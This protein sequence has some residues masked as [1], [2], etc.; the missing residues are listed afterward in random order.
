MKAMVLP[1]PGRPLELREVP[2]PSIGPSDVLVQ[3]RA[4][5]VGLTILKGF[6]SGRVSGYPRIPG[7]EICGTVAAVGADARD[8]PI[9]RRVTCHYYLTCGVCRFCREGRE[10][11]CVARSGSIGRDIDG[12][13]AEFV[14]LP[15]RNVIAVPDGVDDV[16]AAIASDAIA[17]PYRA[18]HEA[19]LRGGESVLVIGA[20]GGVGIHVVQIA[21][22]DGARVIA[23]DISDAKLAL[24]RDLGADET[25]DAREGDIA[26]RVRALTG[27]HGVD[28]VID[29]VGSTATLRAGLDSLGMGGRL[30][31]VGSAP[32]DGGER[33]RIEI[34]P[35][36][37]Q[38]RAIKIHS[39]RY[40]STADITRVL[41][42]LSMRRIRAVVTR[43]FALSQAEDAHEIIR[44]NEHAGRFALVMSQ[45][46]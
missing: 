9:G 15:A 19:R 25:I 34:D 14:R 27:G 11:L 32:K 2:V 8:V 3:V 16:A 7:H 33:P 39:S 43:T 20:G 37:L 13:Y 4:C 31:L 35:S 40:V 21:R 28:A 17:T 10:S 46:V 22:L 26:A 1:G 41:E 6:A 5:G 18:C 36:A 45:L 29:L 44:R 12:G 42:L 23:A 38:S 24:A 30:V